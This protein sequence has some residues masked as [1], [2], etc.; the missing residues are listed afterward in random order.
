MSVAG[1]VAPGPVAAT[2]SA[3]SVDRAIELL[4]NAKRPVV[5]AGTMAY[6]SA[7]GDALLR[8]VEKTRIP[9]FT[10]ERARGMIPDDHTLCF[11]D[12][13]TTANPAAGMMQHA[14]VVLVLGEKIDCRFAYGLSFGH[15]RLIHA[16][17]DADEIGKNRH[18]EVGAACDVGAFVRELVEAAAG[19]RWRDPAQW[20]ETLAES[21]GEHEARMA[22]FAASDETPPHPVR[23]C[24]EVAPFLTDRTILVFD[25]GDFSGWARSCMKARRP[26]GW[27]VGTILGQMGAGMPYALGAK[28]AEPD[29]QVV[30]LTGDGALGFGVMEFET[31]VRQ[32][33]PMV[34]VVGNDSAWGIE[35]H[36][37]KEWYGS[38]RLVGTRLTD[39]RW[40]RMAEAMGGFGAY[41]E[42]PEELKP[43]MERAFASGKPA[44]VNVAIKTAP[45]PQA[46]AYSR[47]FVRRRGL[48]RKRHAA[49]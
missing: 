17:P 6:W 7:C 13:Y 5:M 26:G 21:A 29:S 30:L 24:R 43:A 27:Q 10:V 1:S 20:S 47:V 39:V 8:F 42:R 35:V 32:G 25:G 12:G 14:D 48:I 45:S 49:K 16:Y 34:V 23:I 44:C 38:E 19:R 9:L 15:A 46:H 41:V 22:A 11:G 3:E 37:Q 40:D 4:A 18:A 2:A 28:V 33:C 36:F 31:A